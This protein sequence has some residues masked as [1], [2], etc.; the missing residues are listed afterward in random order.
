M[1]EKI[2]LRD[3]RALFPDRSIPAPI[4]FRAHPWD[5]GATYWLPGSYDP[6]K[7]SLASIKP[8]PSLLPNVWLCGESWC[9]KQAWVE[10]ALEQTQI[11]LQAMKKTYN[12]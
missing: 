5:T 3:V 11:C 9:L 2:L 7:E 8:L 12:I 10:G 1:L 4:F 6:E